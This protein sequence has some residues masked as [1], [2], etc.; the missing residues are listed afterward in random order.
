MSETTRRIGWFSCGAA[1]A[2][3]CSIASPDIVAYC[4][5]NSE[6]SDNE[7]FLKDCETTFKWIVHRIQSETYIDTWNVWE[8]K[9]YISGINGAPCTGE[10]KIKPRLKFQ[11]PGDTHIFGYTADRSDMRRAEALR[12]HYPE[13]IIETPLI[14]RGITKSACRH[15]LNRHGITE[16]LT[17]SLG[18]P[19]A[20]CLP[21]CKA[22]SPSYWALIRQQ[23]PAEFERMAKLS[24][25]L[26]ARLAILKGN[27]IFIDEIPGDQPTTEPTQ[28]HCDFLCQIAENDLHATQEKDH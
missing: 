17:Y 6:H 26:N 19:N 3:A 2:I 12:E 14:E 1:S 7:R 28:P 24:R 10:L 21:C 20:N 8:K 9:R 4:V 18:L 15:L 22:T 23:F 5:T 27:R 16:P 25:T 11:Q 13:L